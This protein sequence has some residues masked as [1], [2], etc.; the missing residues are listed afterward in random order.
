M[1]N[2]SV[3]PLPPKI[4]DIHEDQ[5]M[6]VDKTEPSPTLSTHQEKQSAEE[7]M[8][9]MIAERKAEREL[10]REE[11]ARKRMEKERR[12]KDREIK[13]Q[14]KMKQKTDNMIK[15]CR[16]FIFNVLY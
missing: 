12:R 2:F 13:R 14:I 5:L 3:P 9:Q 16:I 10:R 8:Q 4:L 15:V 1:I 7:T 11:K 6:Q